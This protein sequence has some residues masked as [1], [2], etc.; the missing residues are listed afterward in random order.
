MWTIKYKKLY[1]LFFVIFSSCSSDLDITN[2][3]NEDLNKFNFSDGYFF[4]KKSL[5][6]GNIIKYDYEGG[7]KEFDYN[8]VDGKLNGTQRTYNES[9]D[10]S[11]DYEITWEFDNNNLLSYYDRRTPKGKEIEKGEILEFYDIKGNIISLD[12]DEFKYNLRIKDNGDPEFPIITSKYKIYESSNKDS[13]I[14]EKFESKEKIIFKNL[15][16]IDQVYPKHNWNKKFN[17]PGGDYKR[18]KIDT[19]LK[20]KIGT[21]K[22]IF[23]FSR[24]KKLSLNKEIISARGES[25]YS[26]WEEYFLNPEFSQ[27]TYYVKYEDSNGLKDD[28]EI[29]LLKLNEKYVIRKDEKESE[30][31]YKFY[32]TFPSQIINVS[33]NIRT[34]YSFDFSTGNYF[35]RKNSIYLNSVIT[36]SLMIKI[37]DKVRE[38]GIRSYSDEEKIEKEKII[39]ELYNYTETCGYSS[40]A[41]FFEEYFHQISRVFKPGVEIYLD[42]KTCGLKITN[43]NQESKTTIAELSLTN[44]DGDGKYL[45]KASGNYY[46][47]S[48]IMDD[49]TKSFLVNEFKM[50]VNKIDSLKV[51]NKDP[52]YN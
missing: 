5:Y 36:D 26:E 11:L 25:Y 44:E 19:I 13:L 20:N 4:Y 7:N 49:K 9:V 6:T 22:N 45:Y 21:N 47:K 50:I 3:S 37:S 24:Y 41:K 35:L 38:N 29:R 23:S 43:I 32:Y 15:N 1:I 31:L 28:E 18:F 14:Y 27:Q 48:R 40:K 12:D 52:L 30:Y 39:L 42:N 17:F 46:G 16:S 10:G 8:F 51:I 2:F 34:R 33:N